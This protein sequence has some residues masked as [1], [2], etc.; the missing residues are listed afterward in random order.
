MKF[1]Q[2]QIDDT[3]IP[4]INMSNKSILNKTIRDQPNWQKGDIV[5]LLGHN[6]GVLHIFKAE[7]DP[8]YCSTYFSDKK[9]WYYGLRNCKEIR[10]ATINDIDH[11]IKFQKEKVEREQSRLDELL[12]FREILENK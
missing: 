8:Q 4:K 2:E 10:P 5:V 6:G 3:V 9:D 1:T 7:Y 12:N 11:K